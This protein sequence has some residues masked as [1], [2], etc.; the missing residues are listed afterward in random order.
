M[1]ALVRKNKRKLFVL[2][3]I[4]ASALLADGIITPSITIVSAVEGIKIHYP[5]FDVIPVALLIV[6]ICNAALV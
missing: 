5:T 3:I 6:V 1:Y 2:A 4:G